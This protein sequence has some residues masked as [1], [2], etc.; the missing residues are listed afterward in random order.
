M[1]KPY[2]SATGITNPVGLNLNTSHSASMTIASIECTSY[3]LNIGDSIDIYLGYVGDYQK[4]FSGYVK[5]ITKKVPDLTYTITAYDVLTR[6]VDFFI[7]SENPD[8]A[9]TRRNIRAEDL[10]EDLLALAQLTDYDSDSTSFTFATRQDMQVNLVSAYD[11]SKMIADLLTWHL[12]ADASGTVHFVNRKPHVMVAG[13]PESDQ[14]HFNADPVGHDNKIIDNTTI[15]TLSHSKSEKDLRNRVVVYGADDV[16]GSASH[17]SSIDPDTGGYVEVLPANYYKSAVLAT[18]IIDSDDT[19]NDTASYNLK[20][21]NRLSSEISMTVIGDPDL[22]ART[23][24][25]VHQPFL[26]INGDYYIF[27]AEHVVS[28]AG[29]TVNMLLRK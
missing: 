7:V 23:V 29:Y 4:V 25:H 28:N 14:P 3:N 24:V 17:H 15:L 21:L 2:I 1:S 6:A 12:Y 27:S 18:Y 26:D 22:I 20:L 13:S 10:V 9:F 5:Q 11:Y 16:S 8:S 19:A